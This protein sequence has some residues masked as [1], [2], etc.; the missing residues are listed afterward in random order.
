MPRLRELLIAAISPPNPILAPA[1]FHV[2]CAFAHTGSSGF[3][4][5][6]LNFV[7][8][9]EPDQ[10]P[11]IPLALSG[12]KHASTAFLHILTYFDNCI[13]HLPPEACAP[14]IKPIQTLFDVVAHVTF[15]ED[16][17]V[18]LDSISPAEE[19]I[20][21]KLL[22]SWHLLLFPQNRNQPG[23]L[24]PIVQ[25]A[26]SQG[27][28]YF[29]CREGV[30]WRILHASADLE[31]LATL[32]R[33]HPAFAPSAMHTVA[34]CTALNTQ[35]GSLVCDS[36]LQVNIEAIGQIIVIAEMRQRLIR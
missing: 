26:N 13:P 23:V 36:C 14:A 31:A 10:N 27:R 9:T 20:A 17:L 34:A 15:T 30:W 3:A 29:S 12:D 5:N 7:L 4:V 21:D 25:F 8:A 6:A 18:L 11:L 35:F 22:S 19:A 1:I 2:F 32:A 16:T 33:K 28:H 24:A